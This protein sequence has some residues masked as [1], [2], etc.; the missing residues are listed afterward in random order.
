[1]KDLNTTEVLDFIVETV[2][3]YLPKLAAAIFTL[4]LGWWI[5]NKIVKWFRKMV[6]VL[7]FY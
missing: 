4:V 2:K 7:I 6:S 1:M 3:D 5:I